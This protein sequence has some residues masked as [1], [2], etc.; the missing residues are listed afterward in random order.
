VAVVVVVGAAE[1]DVT[2]VV[3]ALEVV[4]A[5]EVVGPDDPPPEHPMRLEA[6][7][8]SSYQNVLAAEPYD[9]H[10]KYTPEIFGTNLLL[11]HPLALALETPG[12]TVRPAMAAP[13]SQVSMVPSVPR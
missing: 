3:V 8:M 10:P 5:L 12:P 1:V 13:L 9:S 4:L 6:M 2:R 7:A 11:V